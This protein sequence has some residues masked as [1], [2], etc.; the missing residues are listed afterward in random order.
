MAILP[1]A[2]DSSIHLMRAEVPG[3]TKDKLVP[4]MRGTAMTLYLIYFGLSVILAILLRLGGMPWY[5]AVTYTFNTAATG[6][7][8]VTNSGIVGYNSV[9]IEI[10]ITV[11][12]L[13]FGINFYCYYMILLGRWKKAV[14]NEELH[15][16]LGIALGLML[17]L[18][19][20]AMSHYGNNF[21]TSLRYSSFTVSSLMT[22]TGFATA[23]Y[24]LWPHVSRTLIVFVMLLG[25]CAGSTAGGPKTA[26]ILIL[27]RTVLRELRHM[28]RPRSVEQVRLDGKALDEDT[29]RVTLVYMVAHMFIL[30]LSCLLI[31][32]DN[33]PFEEVFSGVLSCFNNVGPGLGACGPM[34]NYASFSYFSK[35]VLILDM[36][37]GRLEIFPV[38]LAVMSLTKRVRSYH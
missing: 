25:G 3:P 17:L 10:V 29:I 31:A 2:T 32:F 22:T 26:R 16:Y 34:G 23:D 18:S 5:E 30:A 15:W 21:F 8:G 7:F 4:R 38:L 19:L 35:I 28:I 6:G 13:L 20:C 1:S 36:L 33:I 9:Y 12:M 27:W 14:I 24:N 11:F 37:L